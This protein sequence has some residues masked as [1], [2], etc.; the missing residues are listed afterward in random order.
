MRVLLQCQSR[1]DIRTA[2]DWFLSSHCA[3]RQKRRAAV[4]KAFSVIWE[5]VAIHVPSRE[6]M[7]DG[8]LEIVASKQVSQTSP[9]IDAAGD[10]PYCRSSPRSMLH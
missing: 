10:P 7:G 5:G 1:A 2:G 6:E 4:G 9:E 8:P 3:G